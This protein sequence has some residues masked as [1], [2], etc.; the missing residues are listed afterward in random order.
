MKKLLSLLTVIFLTTGIA[1]AEEIIGVW[2]SMPISVYIE[3]NRNAYLMKRSFG[4]WESSSNKLVRFTYTDNEEEAKIVV[5]FVDKVSDKAEHAV[6]LT[7][8]YTD[9]QKNFIHAKIE[10]AKYSDL[11]T[12]KLPNIDLLKIMRHEIGH[13]I[14]LPHT[15]IPYAIMN[16][17]TSKGLNITKDD[18]KALKG[19]YEKNKS[20]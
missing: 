3:E 13:A 18:I 14:G 1:R 5:K 17:T 6:G 19:I 11:R 12:T 10:I 9:G 16:P 7:Y 15:N 2:Q 20:N 4:D 8:P